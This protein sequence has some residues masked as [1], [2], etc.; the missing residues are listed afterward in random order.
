M[1]TSL[2][3]I[4]PA[5]ALLAGC[6]TKSTYEQ[7]QRELE[8]TSKQLAGEEEHGRSLTAALSDAE[9]NVRALGRELDALEAAATELRTELASVVKDRSTLEASI[10][11][12]EQALR[13]LRDRRREAEARAAEY[14]SLLARFRR[15]IDAGTL[16]V[17]VSGGRIMLQLRT[18]V[19]F[20]TGRS[21]L[22]E[23]GED[24]IVEIAQVLATI[25]GKHF[26]VEGHTDNVPIRNA[27][28][29]SNWEL[30]QARALRVVKAM[31]AAGM[32]A[33]RISTAAFSE[34]RPTA[35]ND[36]KE[37]R[38]KNRRIEIV[39]L[40]DLTEIADG[41]IASTTE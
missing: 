3:A 27:R 37:G 38:A 15:M 30:A 11:E 12:M 22:S 8:E 41:P 16:E 34:H 18:D 23:A 14:R 31:T 26:Q 13:E 25:E 35:T 7:L 28:Y 39:M 1:R 6:V 21:V 20:P 29:P 36:T 19:L 17:K 24:A 10:V 40:P 32:P 33:D 5:V 9:R 2:I 4:L